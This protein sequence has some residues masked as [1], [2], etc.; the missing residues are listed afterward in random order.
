MRYS[1]EFEVQSDHGETVSETIHKALVS[2]FGSIDEFKV[3][4]SREYV[5][6]IQENQPI[7]WHEVPHDGR[8]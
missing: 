4:P 5:G 1:V 2:A 8:P 7:R 6:Y 3:V